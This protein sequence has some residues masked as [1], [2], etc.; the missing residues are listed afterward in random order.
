MTEEEKEAIEILA[1]RENDFD[2]LYCTFRH[3]FIKPYDKAIDIV[4][5]LIEKQEKVIQGLN[6]QA[7]ELV[8]DYEKQ[9]QEKNEYI[10][11]LESERDRWE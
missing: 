8:D 7:D 3:S 11:R 2:E 5:N 6:K 10:F 4:L 9:L 1:E